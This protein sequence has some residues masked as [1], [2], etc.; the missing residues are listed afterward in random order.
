MELALCRSPVQHSVYFVFKSLFYKFIKPLS[1]DVAAPQVL[2]VNKKYL[3]SYT[4]KTV[5]MWTSES[6]DQSWWTEDNAAE[7]L[8]VLL[9][10]LQSAFECRTL[11]H[12]FVSSVNLLDGVLVVLASRVVDTVQS[13]LADPAAVVA[14]LESYF[15]KVEVFFNALP[16]QAKFENVLENVVKLASSFCAPFT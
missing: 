5:M 3:A 12:Y 10:A 14:Q 9:L 4:A 15:K 8:T 7:C 2:L 13:I 11:D 1:A 6:V 16:E